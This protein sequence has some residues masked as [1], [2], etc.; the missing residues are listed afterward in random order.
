VRTLA[1]ALL[2]HP[3]LDRERR[4]VTTAITNLDLHDIARSAYTYGLLRCY[5][6]HPIAAQRELAERVRTHWTEGSGAVRIPDRAA[7]L[8]ALEI[9][10]SLDAARAHL[11]TLTGA[12]TE[13]WTTSATPGSGAPLSFPEA[14]RRLEG[15]GPPVLIAL[16]TGW[17]LAD[18]VHQSA[19]C[20]LEPIRS[21]R[22]DGYNHLSVRAAAAITFDRLLAAGG[23]R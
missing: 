2:H 8:G 18:S 7:P 9:V 6:S 11:S 14:R 19:S 1:V 17:G 3:V 20:R 22:P 16:G 10:T 4:I 21:P 5:V 12:D 15:Q 23:E 13:L